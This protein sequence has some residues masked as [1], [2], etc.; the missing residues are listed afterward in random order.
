MQNIAMRKAELPLWKYD[1]IARSVITAATFREMLK[2]RGIKLISLTEPPVDG[3]HSI[4]INSV[5]D[6]MAELYSLQLAENTL[7]GQKETARRG[8]SPAADRPTV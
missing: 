3:P 7:R 5:L 6:A 4:I 2:R 8:L 1:R